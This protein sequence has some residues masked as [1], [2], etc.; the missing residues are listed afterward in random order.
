MDTATNVPPDLQASLICEDVRQEVNGMQTLVGI[1]NVIPARVLPVALLKLCVWTR[2]CG[3]IGR[4]RQT[5]RILG[6]DEEKVLAESQIEFELKELESHVTNVNL[7]TGVQLQ[8]YGVHYVEILLEK[9]LRIRYPFP[10][11]QV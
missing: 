2:W 8:Q 3:G 7:F 11:V 4:F 9:E 1:I 6:V 10:V 5:S